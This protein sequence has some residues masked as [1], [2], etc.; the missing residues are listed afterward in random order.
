M[1]GLIFSCESHNPARFRRKTANYRTNSSKCVY[2]MLF[3]ITDEGRS[4]IP[5]HVPTR[6]VGQ[7]QT[8]LAILYLLNK[9]TL[10]PPTPT[11][12]NVLPSRLSCNLFLM[13]LFSLL[14]SVIDKTLW[15]LTT[16]CNE[17]TVR[18]QGVLSFLYHL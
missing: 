2:Y 17:F 11:S 16:N 7:R 3:S 15:L 9:F 10:V 1:P 12:S 13:Y 18:L 8:I 5:F 4:N 14:I 6:R